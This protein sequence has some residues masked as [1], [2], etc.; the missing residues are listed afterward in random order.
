MKNILKDKA[1]RYECVD[2][3]ND[4]NRRYGQKVIMILRSK[5]LIVNKKIKTTYQNS[6]M[7]KFE[8]F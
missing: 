8:R 4:L 6:P 5:D 7:V 1:H 3:K 2:R